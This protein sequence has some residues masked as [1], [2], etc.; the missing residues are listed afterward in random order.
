M[1]IAAFA[2]TGQ[3]EAR[4]N[5]RV[6]VKGIAGDFLSKLSI[7][8]P[9][10]KLP[11]ILRNQRRR[12]EDV[13]NEDLLEPCE[14]LAEACMLDPQCFE[15]VDQ[16]LPCNGNEPC[17]EFSACALDSISA[18]MFDIC[19]PEFE[20]CGSDEDCLELSLPFPETAD[21]CEENELCEDMYIC[22]LLEVYDVG[23]TM[24]EVY[25]ECSDKMP[26][27]WE[28]RD[29]VAG[30]T[31]MNTAP[32]RCTSNELCTEITIC[33]LT[34]EEYPTQCM[35]IISD[36]S[37]ETQCRD[38]GSFL[39]IA[40]LPECNPDS[41]LCLEMNRCT[42]ESGFWDWYIADACEDEFTSCT[43][44]DSC[45][46][47][48]GGEL[49]GEADCGGGAKCEAYTE[50]YQTFGPPRMFSLGEGCDNLILNKGATC[51][52]VDQYG[53]NDECTIGVLENAVLNVERWSVEV[54]DDCGYDYLEIDDVTFCGIWNPD[55]Q[56]IA[57]GSM[58][59]R[60]DGG[61]EYD[62]FKICATKFDGSGYIPPPV[63]PINA[64]LCGH[65]E[66]AT[67]EHYGNVYYGIKYTDGQEIASL[68]D[69]RR[70]DHVFR[71]DVDGEFECSNE[72]F[73]DPIY[74]RHKHCYCEPYEPFLC[75]A[76]EGAICECWGTVF[77]GVKYND[78][79]SI[80]DFWDLEWEEHATK[81]VM[82]SI[83][84][85]NAEFGDPIHGREKQCFCDPLE[86]DLD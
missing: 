53:Y 20:A 2:L 46:A 28:D 38:G 33:I 37:A 76:E 49:P 79:N 60:T 58:R 50:C 72:E 42:I 44:D 29:C 70:E 13:F 56:T 22:M 6:G 27:C 51:V 73:G 1:L 25:P 85:S 18:Y 4:P 8:K 30:V 77:Y 26:E 84:C 66:G 34:L 65:E 47:A 40:T 9:K 57:K 12:Q 55:G 81:I 82:G 67:F 17:L 7:G 15:S 3:V 52:E 23:Y 61:G 10:I 11:K 48:I 24:E 64:I 39:Q 45:L 14:D 31:T 68:H 41:E 21:D 19:E 62:G 63:R 69:L 35:D 86:I 54:D 36:C 80:A 59:W 16:E 5:P 78:E 74:G 71:E 75:A 32:G 43:S 83:E